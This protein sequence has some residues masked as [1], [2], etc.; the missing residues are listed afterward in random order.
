MCAVRAGQLRACECACIRV[1]VCARVQ[2]NNVAK[3]GGGGRTD[4]KSGGWAGANGQVG[5]VAAT[6]ASGRAASARANQP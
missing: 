4:E 3:A 2:N 1:C 5:G 6:E